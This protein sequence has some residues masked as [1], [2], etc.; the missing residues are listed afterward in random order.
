MKFSI[1][2]LLLLITIVGLIAALALATRSRTTT[3]SYDYYDTWEVQESVVAESKWVD[4][5]QAPKL[6]PSNVYQTTES[7][8]TRLNSKST[9]GEISNW[10]VIRLSLEELDSIGDDNWAYVVTLKGSRLLGWDNNRG[11][12]ATVEKISLLVLLTGDVLYD[13]TNSTVKFE[14]IASKTGDT[15][16]LTQN[17]IENSFDVS[18]VLVDDSDPFAPSSNSDNVESVSDPFGSN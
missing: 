12:M 11:G 17:S 3:I 16:V 7:I 1:S 13:S 18:D 15:V 8:A 9:D 4:K 2:N 6:S 10:R 5:S 14:E